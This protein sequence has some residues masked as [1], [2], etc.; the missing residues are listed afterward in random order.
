MLI[1]RA[2]FG[3]GPAVQGELRDDLVDLLTGERVS[4]MLIA[5][6]ENAA[7]LRRGARTVRIWDGDSDREYLRTIV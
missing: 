6:A 3:D 7:L 2:T 1:W 5:A 4:P